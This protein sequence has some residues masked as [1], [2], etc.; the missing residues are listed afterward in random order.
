M[1]S[2]YAVKSTMITH[3]CSTEFRNIILEINKVLALFVRDH[4]VE[5]N[6]LVAP[7]EVVD[8][9]LVSEFLLDYEQ[10]LEKL[11]NSFI[12]VK[13]IELSNHCL[14]ILQI[15]LVLVDQGISFVND[16]ADVIEHLS[17]SMLFQVR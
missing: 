6:V 4:I 2:S 13:V 17:I 8:D 5:V 14:L 15:F 9:A 7:F 1:A 16:T 12:D 10:V 11:D 3:N